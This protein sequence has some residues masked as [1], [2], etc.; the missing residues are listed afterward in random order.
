MNKKRRE[1]VILSGV[2]TQIPVKELQAI[3]MCK[4]FINNFNSISKLSTQNGFSGFLLT[5]LTRE[6]EMK[7]WEEFEPVNIRS[8]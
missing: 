4:I 8:I 6:T 3:F 7:F 5:S 2:F 1:D